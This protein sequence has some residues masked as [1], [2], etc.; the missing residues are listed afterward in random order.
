MADKNAE[1][2]NVFVSFE[3]KADVAKSLLPEGSEHPEAERIRQL[4]DD[5]FVHAH[6]QFESKRILGRT[7][8]IEQE[9]RTTFG[10][11]Q[12]DGC[13][14]DPERHPRNASFINSV[15]FE[16]IKAHLKPIFRDVI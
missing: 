1:V 7:P 8:E 11:M 10:F 4:S 3:V 12:A 16:K 2:V 14:V 6:V 15:A 13:P 5:D 9:I